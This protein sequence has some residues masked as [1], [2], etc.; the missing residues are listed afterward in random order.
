MTKTKTTQ[1]ISDKEKTA[2][3]NLIRAKNTKIIINDTDKN[4]GAADA[5]KIDVISECVRN[6]NDMKTHLKLTEGKLK[7]IYNGHTKQIKTHGG[8]LF[9]Q[10]KLHEKRGRLFVVKNVRFL[11][12]HIFI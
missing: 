4:M 10:G 1:N 6:L 11:T 2:L 9:I 7:N 3:R 5:D 8:K 12:F